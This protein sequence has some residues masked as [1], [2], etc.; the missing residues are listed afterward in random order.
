[1]LNFPS[2]SCFWIIYLFEMDYLN[3]KS[4]SNLVNKDFVG[5]SLEQ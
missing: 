4:N 3:Q 5:K 1:M 2:L